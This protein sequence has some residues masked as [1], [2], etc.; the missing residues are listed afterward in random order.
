ME[1]NNLYRWSNPDTILL[2]T[3]LRDAPHLLPHAIAQARQNNA[4][5]LLVHVIEPAYLRTNPAEGPPFVLPGP[6]VRSVQVRLNRIVKHFQQKGILCE[7]ITLQ[8]MPKEEIAALIRQREVDRV[9]VGTRSA[10]AMDRIILGSV[11]EDLLHEV[12]V[13][14]CIIGPHVR[15][16]VWPDHKPASILLATSLHHKNRQSALLALEIANL[17]QSHLT[18]LHVM[19]ARSANRKELSWLHE[20]RKEELFGLI[21]LESKLWSSPGIAIREGDVAEEILAEAA[22]VSADLIVLGTTAASKV[23][24]LLAGGV[25]HRVIAQAKAPVIT[26]REEHEALKGDV[27][28]RIAADWRA[29]GLQVSRGF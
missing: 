2:A 26:L 8:G 9:I 20:S 21:T 1:K 27:Q 16:Q 17:Y 15:P 6:T 19:T 29:A 7:P 23:S 18:L 14:T 5:V 11:A 25:V 3:N 24:R 10:E 13:P 22:N 28:K 12:D 4:K